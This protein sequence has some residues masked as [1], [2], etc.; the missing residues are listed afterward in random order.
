MSEVMKIFYALNDA[1]SGEL[2]ESNAGGAELGFVTGKEQ[3]IEALEKELLNMQAGD[4]KQIKIACADALGQ[5]DESLMQLLPKEQFAGIELKVGM[6][7][8]GQDEEGN[9]V[10]AIV[11][12]LQGDDVLLDYNHPYA[13]KD[14]IFDIHLTERRPADS[15]EELTG[16]VKMPHT[17]CCGGHHHH[18]HGHEPG[19]CKK[20]QKFDEIYGEHK[21]HECGCG[22]HHHHERATHK[23]SCGEHGEHGCGGGHHHHHGHAEHECGCGGH[24][25]HKHKDG[26]CCGG[27]CESDNY[28]FER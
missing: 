22:G 23:D 4:K 9:N 28:S 18:E 19:S 16:V 8:I 5:R 17:C 20:A 14:L 27:E 24:G 6:P 26:G 2:L 3:V 13:G 1:N 10:H 7:L 21:E 11:S 15:D 12:K 25:E